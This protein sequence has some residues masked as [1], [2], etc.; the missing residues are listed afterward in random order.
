MTVV[1]IV[2]GV[3]AVL[4]LA[5][6]GFFFW[7][8]KIRDPLKGVDLYDFHVEQKWPWELTLTPEQEKAFM[9]GLE[10]YDNN[11]GG[12]SLS[13]REGYLHTYEPQQ[14]ISLFAMTEQFAAMGPAAMQDPVRAVHELVERAEQTEGDGVL[15]I[16]EEW[17][18][19]GVD[20]ID[21]MDKYEF[22]SAAMDATDGRGVDHEGG[23]AYGDENFG[24]TTRTFAIRTPEHVRQ[25]YSDAADVAGEPPEIRNQL[26]VYKYAMRPENPE[27]IAAYELAEAEESKYA[28]TLMFCF[29]R[30]ATEY[31]AA[32][33]HMRQVEPKDVLSVVMARMVEQGLPGFAWVRP[34]SQEQYQLALAMLRNRG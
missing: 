7:F 30:L 20:E 2:L 5:V 4:G 9:T 24:Y 28:N 12:C 22:T 13:R 16:N 10:A 32:R 23:G 8:H 6:G 19:E 31:R 17:M 3:L 14:L 34:P 18:G 25:M 26:D 1:F 11:E 33:P 29:E 15:H 27:H 21:G